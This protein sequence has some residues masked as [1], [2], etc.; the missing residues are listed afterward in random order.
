MLDRY[1]PAL[2][3]PFMIILICLVGNHQPLILQTE[4][5][6]N[7]LMGIQEAFLSKTETFNK[8][9]VGIHQPLFSRIKKSKNTWLVS[10]SFYYAII[11]NIKMPR[12][13]PPALYMEIRNFQKLPDAEKV[14]S[15]KTAIQKG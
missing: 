5:I 14:S 6:K 9:L 7:C 8:C 13:Y 3:M 12:G 11:D 1:S 2:F 10:T 4:T 15:R